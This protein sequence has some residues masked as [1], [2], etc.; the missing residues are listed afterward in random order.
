MLSKK[1]SFIWFFVIGYALVFGLFHAK[2]DGT[3]HTG[4]ASFYSKKLAGKKTSSGER[5]DPYLFTAAHRTLPMG[6]WVQIK[7][8]R[9]DRIS[10]VRI[11]DRGPHRKSRLID[12]SYVAAKEL[13]ILS[14]GVSQVIIR[15]LFKEDLTD[16]LF[17]ALKEKDRISKSKAPK[18]S[19]K[20]KKPKKS[21]K[22]KKSK[23]SKKSKKS[24]KSKTLKKSK[25]TNKSK[26]TQKTKKK[27]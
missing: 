23:N 4:H 25:K 20:S 2:A 7:S 22:A 26:K 3:W 10:Y 24:K 9:T 13:G 16:S 8:L 5:F 15:P 18:K 17:H 21:K 19:K 27:K 1:K 6:T 14:H 11:N 12:V